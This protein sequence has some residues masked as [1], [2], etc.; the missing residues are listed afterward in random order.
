MALDEPGFRTAFNRF[1]KLVAIY[2]GHEFTSLNEGLAAVWEGYKPKL[3]DLALSK[4]DAANW[5]HNTIGKGGI[6]DRTIAAIEIQDNRPG[7]LTNNFVFWQN[8]YGHLSREHRALLDAQQDQGSRR[9]IE[10]ALFELYR[11]DTDEG[12]LFDRLS[13]LTGRKYTLSAY[14]YFLKDMSRFMPIQPTG[15]DRVFPELGV[16]FT[17]LKNCNWDNYKRFNAILGEVRL[18]LEEVAD[19]KNVRL[20]DAHSFC[21]IFATLLKRVPEGA[22]TVTQKGRDDGR[23]LGA[24]ERSI[25]NMRLSI[26]NTVSQ[27]RGQIVTRNM[28][29]KVK[30]LGFDS[31][32]ELEAY[33]RE[34]MKIQGDRCALT[35][36]AFHFHGD[37]DSDKNL[38]PSPDRIDSDGHYAPGNIQVVCQFVNM[39]K[40]NTKNEE[41]LR[42]L[43]LIRNQENG[44]FVSP[45]SGGG[46]EPGNS[47][48]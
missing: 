47:L 33:L 19:L 32:Q 7:G 31:D 40:S 12:A 38:L 22:E 18:A 36:I 17:S 15:F 41:F 11:T 23:V 6:L 1:Q 26:L 45:Q 20:V 28:Q 2:S 10:N 44:E 27:S 21:W 4:L 13:E 30:D 5:Q 24:R 25:T 16:R 42:L 37:F 14:L 34:R 43:T 46:A 35:G 39:W 9:A 29:M 8:R 48:P 3:R